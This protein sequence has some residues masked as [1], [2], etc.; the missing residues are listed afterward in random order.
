MA[1]HG[2]YP[3]LL[4]EKSKGKYL[5]D[6]DVDTSVFLTDII[7]A[8]NAIFDIEVLERSNMK[9]SSLVIDTLKVVKIL[10]SE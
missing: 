9:C 3:A 5:V 7:I 2:I 8:H 6:I 10:L 4:T 1:I